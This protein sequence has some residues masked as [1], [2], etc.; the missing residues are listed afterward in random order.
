M[1]TEANEIVEVILSSAGK[2]MEQLDEKDRVPLTENSD[3][4]AGTSPF[5]SLNL[6]ALVVELE[7]A[8][9]KKY[10]RH[11]ALA[12]ERS[13]AQ[14]SNPFSNVASLSAYVRLLVAE[15]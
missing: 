12:D 2:I 1:Q 4:F 14:P 5:D 8:L 15:H 3:L 9:E 6:V 11:I 7:Q 10:G 13:M